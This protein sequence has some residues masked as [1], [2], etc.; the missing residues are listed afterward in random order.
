MAC[1]W[2]RGAVEVK[3]EE[4][5]C[6]VPWTSPLATAAAL[7]SAAGPSPKTQM[8]INDPGR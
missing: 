8:V 7:L 4:G 5:V 3:V 1:V 2:C 6:R